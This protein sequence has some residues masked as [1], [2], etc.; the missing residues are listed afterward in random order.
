[1]KVNLCVGQTCVKDVK[2]I[3]FSTKTVSELG[4]PESNCM[5]VKVRLYSDT[6]TIVTDIATT[7]QNI[8]TINE[9]ITTINDTISLFFTM[10]DDVSIS[11]RIT[12]DLELVEI[13]K[14][15]N[16]L[17]TEIRDAVT[18]A[19]NTYLNHLREGN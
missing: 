9:K 15:D 10:S 14:E 2:S 13:Q 8:H 6:A 11:L 19:Y 18:K 7:I 16:T 3:T 1:M 4:N 12:D 17:Y 5:V